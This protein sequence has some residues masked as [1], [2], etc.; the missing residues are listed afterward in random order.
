MPPVGSEMRCPAA[1]C[2]CRD[3]RKL[4]TLP[5][6]GSDGYLHQRGGETECRGLMRENS[7][8]REQI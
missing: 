3:C 1:C 5:L 8:T 7:G 2:Q 6:G 4:W